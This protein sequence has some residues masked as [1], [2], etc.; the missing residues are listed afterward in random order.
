MPMAS[1]DVAPI[2][3]V[4]ARRSAIANREDSESV[5]LYLEKPVVAVK[6]FGHQLDDLK[7]ELSGRQHVDS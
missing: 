4:Q 5:V 2:A 6:R 1:H 7:W 3:G